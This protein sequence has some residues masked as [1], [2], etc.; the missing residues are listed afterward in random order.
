MDYSFK[1]LLVFDSN[2]LRSTDNSGEVVYNS[3]SFGGTYHS[4][5][6]FIKENKLEDN[7][8][9]AIPAFVIEELKRQKQRSYNNDIQELKNI[10]NRLSGLPHIRLDELKIPDVGFSCAEFIENEAR[11]YISDNQI[12]LLELQEQDALS[13][14]TIMIDK[15][16]NYNTPRRPFFMTGSGNRI[17]DAGFKDNVIWE[18]LMHFKGIVDFDKI[19]FV[20]NDNGFSECK[21]EFQAKWGKHFELAT[22][23]ESVKIAL[24]KDYGNYIENREGYE[25]AN[26]DYFKDYLDDELRKVTFVDYEGESIKIENYKVANFCKN[27]VRVQ[28]EEGDFISVDILSEI[29]VYATYNGEKIEIPVSAKTNLSDLENKVIEEINFEPYI[30]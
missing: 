25:Y 30:Y 28:D 20:S 14:L 24:Q 8:K 22:S 4:I 6:R 18:V 2:M 10:I 5:E 17:K 19:I 27:V 12:N 9:L 7:V 23:D 1:T 21:T 26:T 13:I 15:V 11:K 29:I 3:F 16:V